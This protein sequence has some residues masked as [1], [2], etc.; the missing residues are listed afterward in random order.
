LLNPE[1]F[2]FDGFAGKESV[3]QWVAHHE[4]RLKVLLHGI[5]TLVDG[6]TTV[7]TF[8]TWKAQ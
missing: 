3:G 5:F 1:G 4:K 8:K 2:S 7:E 6:E